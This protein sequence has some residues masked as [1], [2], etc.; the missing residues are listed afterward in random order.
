VQLTDGAP[1]LSNLMGKHLNLNL[2]MVGRDPLRLVDFWHVAE[3]LGHAARA[4][5]ASSSEPLLARWKMRLANHRDAA[6]SI[7]A[8]LRASGGRELQVGDTKPVREAIT[9]LQ[10]HGERMDYAWPRDHGLPIGSGNV[11][12]ACKGL[13]AVRMKRPWYPL[14]GS[15]RRTDPPFARARSQRW[16]GQGTQA[17]PR[18][19]NGSP[20]RRRHDQDESHTL[21]GL[22][23][24]GSAPTD[25]TRKV[26][27]QRCQIP[28]RRIRIRIRMFRHSWA[29]S[30]R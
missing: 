26:G 9:Y 4:L 8:E 19:A 24:E 11:K 5:D 28:S 3:K 2:E 1:E 25:A 23:D 12:A 13:V 27:H 10:N 18:T 7:C 6:S 29:L 14:E 17:H 30:D 20:V 21:V 16:L 15:D 22:H